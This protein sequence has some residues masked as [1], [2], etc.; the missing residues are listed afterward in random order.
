MGQ[1]THANGFGFENY[2]EH[3]YHCNQSLLLLRPQILCF[4]FARLVYD[5][6]VLRKEAMNVTNEFI[7]VERTFGSLLHSLLLQRAY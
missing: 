2:A 4:I 7:Y 3:P 1:V 5:G 6:R